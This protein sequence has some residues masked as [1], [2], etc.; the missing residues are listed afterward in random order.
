MA[1]KLKLAPATEPV[2]LSDAKTFLRVS[3][4]VE[5]AGSRRAQK[6]GQSRL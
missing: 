3:G 2:T 1:L 5:D 6:P 4:S